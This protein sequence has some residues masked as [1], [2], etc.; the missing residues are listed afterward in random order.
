MALV[1]PALKRWSGNP[2]GK[3]RKRGR[4]QCTN[5]AQFIADQATAGGSSSSH[6]LARRYGLWL[7]LPNVKAAV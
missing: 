7:T 6:S 2:K 1:S 3:P 4:V 5:V